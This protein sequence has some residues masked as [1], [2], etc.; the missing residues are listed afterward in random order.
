MRRLI[1]IFVAFAI[2]A[3]PAAAKEPLPITK[4]EA[5]NWSEGKVR[6]RVMAQLQDFLTEIRW[7]GAE[8]GP[9]RPKHTLTDME[10][11]T[12]GRA[13]P[14][15]DLCELD[16]LT[17]EFLPVDGEYVDGDTPVS[18]S[19]FTA[20]RLY[21]FLS[22]PEKNSNDLADYE[23]ALDHRAC[24]KTDYWEDEVFPAPS[25]EDAVDGYLVFTVARNAILAG[26]PPF[27]LSCDRWSTDETHSCEDVFKMI[28][29]A[30]IGS[31]ENCGDYM[32]GNCYEFSVDRFGV[33]IRTSGYASEG[34]EPPPLTIQEVS[35]TR[36]IIFAD[37]RVD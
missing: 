31:I 19:G 16:V 34:N 11:I 33:T 18:A 24:A 17:V 30:G 8:E 5:R 6:E 32:K 10:F 27:A 13:T 21:R 28:V 37:E 25:Q 2:F 23:T 1:S 3:G 29:D 14:Y 15:K 12:K 22:P 9:F 4:T 20:R 35:V 7:P 26:K 36:P